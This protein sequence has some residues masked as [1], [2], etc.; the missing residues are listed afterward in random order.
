MLRL[1]ETSQQNQ[2]RITKE[3][4]YKCDMRIKQTSQINTSMCNTE[5]KL[6]CE[7]E[8]KLK[9]ALWHLHILRWH[10]IF[11]VVFHI[12]LF[13]EEGLQTAKNVVIVAHCMKCMH[14]FLK[15]LTGVNVESN[16]MRPDALSV[17]V[18]VCACYEMQKWQWRYA[19]MYVCDVP[20]TF[21]YVLSQVSKFALNVFSSCSS[22]LH[23]RP[24]YKAWAWR[25]SMIQYKTSQ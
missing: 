8:L 25:L 18:C 19:V 15:D 22:P 13:Q 6:K 14:I 23:Q 1:K 5:Q 2:K 11:Y 16:Q 24:C 21:S 12:R 17:R 10:N 4:F 20:R 9:S 7:T 3:Q